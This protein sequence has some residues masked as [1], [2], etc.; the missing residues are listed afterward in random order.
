[1][2]WK[3]LGPWLFACLEVGLGSGQTEDWF[4]SNFIVGLLYRR[5]PGFDR[6][7]RFGNGVIPTRWWK[8]PC[9]PTQLRI[10]CQWVL[11]SS[12]S[13]CSDKR[14]DSQ[15][16]AKPVRLHLYRRRTAFSGPGALVIRGSGSA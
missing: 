1:M 2:V 9:L 7:R 8:P 13:L 10:L 11:L 3:F 4:E 15:M 16:R 14:V 5:A 12:D 6:P